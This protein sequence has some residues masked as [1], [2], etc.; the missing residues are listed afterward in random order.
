LRLGAERPLPPPRLHYELR[1]E[2]GLLVAGGVQET[3]ELGWPDGGGELRLRFEVE[4]LPL[5]DGRFHLRLGLADGEGRLLHQLDD[6]AAFLVVPEGEERGF[7]RLDGHWSGEEIVTA[8]EVP[9]R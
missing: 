3:A 1:S 9:V 5:A 8:A 6:A 7:A 4:R 2:S